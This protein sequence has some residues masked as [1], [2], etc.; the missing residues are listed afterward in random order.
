MED[1]DKT[2]LTGRIYPAIQS[3]VNNRYKIIVGYFLI[4]GFFLINKNELKEVI[5]SGAFYL[6]GIFTI[7]VI[8]NF[9]NYLLNARE[10][11]KLEDTAKTFPIL[12]TVSSIAM[13][14]LIWGGY[15]F[16]TA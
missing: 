10:Q 15:R 3:C 5:D 13:L 8:H 4:V 7:F 9:F 12:E 14:I 16:L 2:I 6:A 11:W 1:R